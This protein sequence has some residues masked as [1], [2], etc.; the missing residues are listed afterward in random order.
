MIKLSR[1][2]KENVKNS[3]LLWSP[4]YAFKIFFILISSLFF[5]NSLLFL[6]CLLLICYLLS[7]TLNFITIFFFIKFST[8]LTYGI[9]L[10]SCFHKLFSLFQELLCLYLNPNAL[11]LRDIIYDLLFL[12]DKFQ[13]S[14]IHQLFCQ[15]VI[16]VLGSP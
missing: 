10:S 6:P 12:N 11:Q 14:I 3:C 4:L 1:M 9:Y 5:V 15:Y 7:F 8:Y 13:V 2:L 16:Y